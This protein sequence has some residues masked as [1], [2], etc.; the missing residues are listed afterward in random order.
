[1]RRLFIIASLVAATPA[2]AQDVILNIGHVLDP[3]HP[4]QIGALHMAEVAAKQ[5]NGRIKINVYPSS[6]LGSD[7][8]ALQSTQAGTI[9]GVIDA[10]AKLANF[11]PE[12]GVLDL[13]Y[14]VSN[15][16]QAYRLLDS[17]MVEQE[18][19]ARAAA[20][21]FRVI[22]H[23]EVT[24]RS[25]Y[26]R[27]KPVNSVADLRGLKIRVI[28]APSYIALFRALGASPTP[29]S[30]GE[31]YTALQQGVVDG[32]EN[33]ILTYQS[34]T[35]A[36]VAKNLAITNHLMLVNS[37]ML[38]EKQWV[39]IPDELKAIIREASREGRK[40]NIEDREA[41]EKTA[42]A[43]LKSAGVRVS[44]PDLKPF[45]DIGRDTYK[46]FEQRLGRE[47]IDKIVAAAR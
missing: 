7:R 45:I 40:R 15:R 16:E 10:T 13:P 14:L 32:A 30:F 5:S 27:A 18:L 3:R 34:T 21:G 25:V 35:H 33:D 11:V 4:V 31:L 28:P 39:R 43:E 9:G 19:N 26:T 37:L 12:F 23:W 38:S 6:Q 46:E 41:R 24:F 20:A 44:E 1:M 36:E 22:N 2:A 47:L 17:A 42:F 29:M 8:E